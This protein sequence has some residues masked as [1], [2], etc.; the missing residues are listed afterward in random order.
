[1]EKI[2]SAAVSL[3]K[4][5]GYRSA[6]NALLAVTDGASSAALIPAEDGIRPLGSWISGRDCK[7]RWI[8][9]RKP[10]WRDGPVVYAPYGFSGVWINHADALKRG[11]AV[12]RGR[13]SESASLISYL[14]ESRGGSAAVGRP[15]CP[16]GLA[17]AVAGNFQTVDK[18]GVRKSWKEAAAESLSGL[19]YSQCAQ[20][21]SA[22]GWS[23][24]APASWSSAAR[25]AA[26]LVDNPER[27][28]TIV[29]GN[30]VFRKLT[31]GWSDS[32][33]GEVVVNRSV[34]VTKMVSGGSVSYNLKITGPGKTW[35]GTCASR[36][37][38]RDPIGV[39][40]YMC[41]GDVCFSAGANAL[42]YRL[43][44]S[45]FKNDGCDPV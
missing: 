35:S 23:G 15:L 32:L 13:P 36:K 30:R 3:S 29:C 40:E 34:T 8:G 41:G 4:I 10:W 22:S 19:S 39:V 17:L 43:A 45:Q 5:G 27:Y 21:L 37:F 18:A 1:M 6:V 28:T 25:S 20:F 9:Y 44:G 11:G 7:W 42:L 14:S 2:Q 16:A 38:R 24:Q 26:C 12:I 33:T 31:Y